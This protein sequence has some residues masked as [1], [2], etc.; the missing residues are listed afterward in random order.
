ME[1]HAI[2]TFLFLFLLLFLVKCKINGWIMVAM[3]VSVVYASVP[4]S[5]TFS[6]CVE[7]VAAVS[8]RLNAKRYTHTLLIAK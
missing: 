5:F 1:E 2:L 7:S 6:S 3:Y 4:F 8:V